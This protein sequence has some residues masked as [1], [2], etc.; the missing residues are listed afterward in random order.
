[1]TQDSTLLKIVVIAAVLVGVI[2]MVTLR[3]YWILAASMGILIPVTIYY[4]RKRK[5]FQTEK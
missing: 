5:T 3:E 4:V 1:M 2:N